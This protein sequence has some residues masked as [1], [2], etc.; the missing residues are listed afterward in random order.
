[1]IKYKLE[2][3][4]TTNDLGSIL[5]LKDSTGD[6]DALTN[7]GGYGDPNT[8]RSDVALFVT[9]YYVSTKSTL[10]VTIKG[11]DPLVATDFVVNLTMDGWYKFNMLAFPIYDPLLLETYNPG[12][13]Y[14]DPI[15][16]GLVSI[17]KTVDGDNYAVERT[18]ES[19][20]NIGYEVSIIDSF[21]IY[22]SSKT[23]VR[24]NSFISDLLTNN[25]DFKDKN[26]IRLKDNYN[27]IRAILQGAVYEFCRGNKY[28]AQ[29]SIEFLNSNNYV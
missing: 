18:L 14:Y 21:I 16:G 8:E 4:N 29:K 10:P 7:V 6:Y 17:K 15:S 19:L 24:L 12:T 2:N 1:M 27:A 20:S 9:A 3:T 11:Y 5:Y 23:K 26:L 25:V 13:A 22:N 28:T